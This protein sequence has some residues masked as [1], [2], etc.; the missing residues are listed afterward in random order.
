MKKIQFVNEKAWRRNHINLIF[1]FALKIHLFFSSVAFFSHWLA[2]INA[3][4]HE[5]APKEC[6]KYLQHNTQ[7]T[8]IE[9]IEK[10]RNGWHMGPHKF[11]IKFMPFTNKERKEERK[12]NSNGKIKIK[13]NMRARLVCFYCQAVNNELN[14]SV[15]LPM[16]QKFL[17]LMWDEASTFTVVVPT[18]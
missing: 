5:K 1:G 8:L 18:K 12:N 17:C 4:V 7:T 6:R 3:N 14:M 13:K 11:S 9:T 2:K 15:C 16:R 10:N